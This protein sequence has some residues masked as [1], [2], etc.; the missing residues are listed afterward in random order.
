MKTYI[1]TNPDAKFGYEIV[2]DDKAHDIVDIVD[3]GKTLKL[4]ENPSN[5]KYY[6]IKKVIEAGGTVELTYKETKTLGPKATGTTTKSPTMK[7]YDFLTDEEKIIISDI[8][9]KAER[10]A[11]KA[12]LLAQIEA[13]KAR[14]EELEALE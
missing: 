8:Q 12:R 11:E 13:D 6:S 14:L 2:F 1:T 7:W 5:R 4:P 9:T 10:R 3:D